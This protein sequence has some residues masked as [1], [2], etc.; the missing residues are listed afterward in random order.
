MYRD[1]KSVVSTAAIVSAAVMTGGCPQVDPGTPQADWKVV[2]SELPGGLLSVSGTAS[3][4]VIVVGADPRD[5]GGPQVFHHDGAQWT[6]LNT[7]AS[8]DLWWITDRQVGDSFFMVG[9]GGMALRYRPATRA[10]EQLAT[11]G[12]PTLFG[13]WGTSPNNV[14]AVGGDSTDPDASGVIWHFDG[15]TWTAQDTGAINPDG[16]PLLF[17]VWGRSESEI[18]AVGTR[19]TILRF[20]GT[21]WSPMTSSTT[22]P[23]FTVHGN[24]DVVV[25]CGGSQSGVIL[26]STGGV[27]ADVTPTGLVQM[28]GAFAAGGTVL[29]VGREGGVA[30]RGASGWTSED[31]GLNL[32]LVL[33]Y[34]AAWI[35]PDGGIWAV[36]G[37]IIGEPQTDGLVVYFGTESVGTTI[38]S[39]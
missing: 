5:G 21:N 11:P 7:G 17:K 23:L 30:F 18:Y 25:A 13:V 2:L 32:D 27:F 4:D 16:I 3:D 9:E 10:F 29:T 31:T 36:G 39:N 20:D 8:G 34:H 22:R 38:T 26:E 37:N 28:N 35:D 15:T 24:D 33:D 19:G 14:F 12:G 6:K 1:S